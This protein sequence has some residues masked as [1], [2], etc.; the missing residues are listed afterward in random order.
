[1]SKIYVVT[2]TLHAELHSEHATLALAWQELQRLSSL[3]WHEPPIRPPC[4]SWQSCSREY[5][6]REYDSDATS[7]VCTAVFPA[8]VMRADAI[9][10]DLA[11]PFAA[12]AD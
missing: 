3:P 7:S 8:L 5:E 11:A 4:G 1:M 10:W 2:D 12:N 6:I 9:I